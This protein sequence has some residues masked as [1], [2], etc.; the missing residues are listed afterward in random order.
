MPSSTS[1]TRRTVDPLVVETPKLAA[2]IQD[3]IQRFGYQ[4][5]DKSNY[6]PDDVE[7]ITP[8]QW[9]AEAVELDPRV[10]RRILSGETETTTLELAERV[11]QAIERPDVLSPLTG[12]IRIIKNPRW[13]LQRFIAYMTESAGE[14]SWREYVVT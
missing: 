13:S 6:T 5:E 3:W 9:L 2:V 11:L 12:T 14:D 1:T 8:M 10:I 4:H 7:P